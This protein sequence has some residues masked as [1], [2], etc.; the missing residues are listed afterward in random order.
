SITKKNYR[1]D[2]IDRNGNYLVKTVSTINIGIKPKEVIDKKHLLLML[3]YIYGNKD[4]SKIKKRLYGNKFF[5]LEKN[6]NPKRYEQLMLLGDKSIKSEESLIRLYPQD[7]LFSHTIGQ[8][9]DNNNGISG[10]EKSY[11]LDLKE[12]NEPL[13]L[14]LDTEIQY[15]IRSEL[16]KYQEIFRSKGS[17]AILMDVNNGE[18]FSMVSLPDFN[19]NRR[20]KIV[21]VNFINR[22]TKG[23]YELG[24][25]FKTFTIA[26]GI[27]E[28]LIEPDTKFSNLKKSIKCGDNHQIREYDD[29]IP[30]DLSAEQILIKSG[31]IGS[32]R[33]ARKIGIK[34]HK[35]FLKSIGIL[36]KIDF[37]IEEVGRPLP[38]DWNEGCKLETISFGHGITTTILQLAKGYSIIV[39]GGYVV[40]PTLIIKDLNKKNKRIKILKNDVSKKIIPILRKTVSE[41]T[42]GQVNV[43]GYQVG[44]KTGTAQQA[45]DKKYSKL[46][47]NTL[48]AIF[49]SE[50]P[51][52]ILIVMLESPKTASEYVYNYRNKEGS[53]KGTPY[54]TAGWTSVEVAGQIMEKIG[55]ILA[56]KYIEN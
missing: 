17:A 42:A 1:A 4:L 43:R 7:N 40:K 11:D 34:K 10:I 2:I 46:K 6:I 35:S 51:K 12:I 47:I 22:V 26:S 53:F 16:V 30:S 39:N 23:T 41:G 5:Y 21:D 44:G 38:I 56:T 29:E 14:T 9:D 31:N 24:S 8:I 37:D 18:I 27:N 32:V 28:G 3:N 19:L 49:P 55:P 25:V 45:I 13:R 15:L 36:D 20:E 52:Y 54:N 48:A 50:K 33:I